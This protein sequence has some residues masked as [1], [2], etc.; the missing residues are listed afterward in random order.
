MKMSGMLTRSSMACSFRPSRCR[1][2][3]SPRMACR[4]GPVRSG[5]AGP[6]G[7][8]ALS[9]SL[10]Q[11]HLFRPLAPQTPE[12]RAA[13]QESPHFRDGETEAQGSAREAGFKSTGLELGDLALPGSGMLAHIHLGTS[14]PSSVKWGRSLNSPVAWL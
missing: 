7:P 1:S 12:T 4:G 6:Q 8:A 11:Q 14:V 2:K 5:A 10:W 9:R 3:A 13:R